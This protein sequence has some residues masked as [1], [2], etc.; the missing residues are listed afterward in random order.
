MDENWQNI[1]TN[2]GYNATISPQ[3]ILDDATNLSNTDV[4]VISSGLINL[5]E[6]R[7]QSIR[8]FVEQGGNLY[9]QSEYLV[10][11][12]GNELF[13]YLINNLG[14]SFTWDGESTGSLAP[15]NV[16]GDLADNL[17][18]V[19]A[20]TY[21]WYGTYGSGD[22]TIHSI[23]EYNNL[24]W[25]FIFCPPTP[26]YGKIITTSDQDWVRTLNSEEL[27][28]NILTYLVSH[29]PLSTLP[30]ISIDMSESGP[31]DTITYTFNAEIENYMGNSDLQWSVNGIVVPGETNATFASANLLE[32]D[33]VE[34]ELILSTFCTS[35]T[36][37]SNPILIA[38]INPI[39][40]ANLEIISNGDTFCENDDITFNAIAT[41]L[42]NA[43]NL[44]YTW[45]ING[46]TV[47]GATLD[48]FTASNLNDQD[49]VNCILTFD[50]N[51]FNGNTLSATPIILNITSTINPTATIVADQ[52]TICE[53]ETITF[54]INGNDLGNN[55][56]FQWQIDG[57]NTGNNSPTFSTNVLSEGQNITCTISTNQ[58]CATM[59]TFTTNT[60]TV[61]VSQS[62]TPSINIS[63]NVTE[64]CQGE[65][66]TFTA[67]GNNFGLNPSFQWQI[68]GIP[69]GT[70]QPEFSTNQLT[71]GQV[72][73]CTLIADL[74]CADNNMVESSPVSIIVT[75]DQS[76]VIF[77]EANNSEICKGQEVIFTAYGDHFGVNPVF[78]WM[79]DGVPVAGTDSIFSTTDLNNDQLVSCQI[80][81]PEACQSIATATSNTVLIKVNEVSFEVLELAFENCE[82]SDGIIEI[83]GIGGTEPYT[84]EWMDGAKANLHTGLAYGKFTVTVTDAIG[85]STIGQIEMGRNN[86]PEVSEYIIEKSDCDGENG[87]AALI[88][89][90]ST[91]SYTF[92][93]LNNDGFTV[94]HADRAENLNTGIYSVIISNEF[95]CTIETYVNIEQVSSIDVSI[96]EDFQLVLGE[97][98]ELEAM[99]NTTEGVTYN[100][101]E[102]ANI[103]CTSCPNPTVSPTESTTYT[104]TATNSYGCTATDRIYIHVNAKRDVYIP[105]AF[106]PNNDG[107][108]DFFTVYSG[109]NVKNIK[110]M[111]LFD[112]WGSEIFSKNDFAPNNELD[113]WDGTT[114]GKK[115]KSGVYVYMIEVEYIDGKTKLHKGDVSITQN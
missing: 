94:S 31:C 4:L 98:F 89:A 61:S 29:M 55:P 112:R 87:T 74:S 69:A 2:L 37:T 101:S 46:N 56:T 16:V 28:A 73:T 88:M 6:I 24:D 19:N 58:S 27:M 49:T 81:N 17:N 93:W 50:N 113:G 48:N 43:S 33:V 11:L 59:N 42:G 77:V 7:Q 26:T 18:T 47:A 102:T 39:A 83:E 86:A 22:S 96:N 109:E 80:T 64:I 75:A 53:G 78:Q 35:Y 104:L 71:N 85:C 97:S 20:I 82:N 10:N 57:I 60:I 100:W 99:V 13:N 9:I 68:D 114:N 30:T 76:P 105:N 115:L 51:C 32:G 65:T 40:G 36:H 52:T 15:M 111:H 84:Y 45:T 92:E 110:S 66:V 72:V 95:G 67:F 8:Q 34:C 106:T 90:D 70:N 103:S 5:P 62:L 14:G 108:N 12:P 107:L 41:D 91:M 79:I 25:G 1:A 63:P 23:L 21:Y 38:P 44:N 3:S 54:T